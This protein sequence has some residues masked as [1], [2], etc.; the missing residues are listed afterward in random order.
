[1]KNLILTLI[2]CLLSMCTP[3]PEREPVAKVELSEDVK[4]IIR[5]YK[6]DEKLLGPRFLIHCYVSSAYIDCLSVTLVPSSFPSVSSCNLPDGYCAIDEDLVLVYYGKG[7][8]EGKH[9]NT[10]EINNF[11][12]SFLYNKV[13]KA[14][15]EAMRTSNEY[16]LRHYDSKEYFLCKKCVN[17]PYI[18]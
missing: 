16:S 13:G 5:T 2:F 15:F 3:V 11:V 18:Q 7:V 8:V 17:R 6:I 14:A 1:M 4:K 9:S 12:A 10:V